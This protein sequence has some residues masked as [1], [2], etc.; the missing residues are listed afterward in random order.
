MS[1]ALLFTVIAARERERAAS[2]EGGIIV[3]GRLTKALPNRQTASGFLPRAKR[4]FFKAAGPLHEHRPVQ[5]WK[6]AA[7]ARV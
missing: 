2:T 6:T 3:E 5:A 1:G 7:I 4:F